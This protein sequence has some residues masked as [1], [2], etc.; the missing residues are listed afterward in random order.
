MMNRQR[1]KASK[2]GASTTELVAG[3]AKY[4]SCLGVTKILLEFS[5]SPDCFVYL[6]LK[7]FNTIVVLGSATEIVA[8]PRAVQSVEIECLRILNF[9]KSVQ[10][11]QLRLSNYL[12]K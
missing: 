9:Y 11:Q 10:Q 1:S 12:P 7:R 2:G 3:Y 4:D 6:L 8:E 5:I